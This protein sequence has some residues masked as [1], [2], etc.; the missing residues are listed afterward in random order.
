MDISA[1]HLVAKALGRDDSNLIANA[2]VGLEIK[3]E[4]WVVSLNDALGGFLDGLPRSN[5]VLSV[6]QF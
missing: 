1:A 3:S 2:L 6:S 5:A 4:L